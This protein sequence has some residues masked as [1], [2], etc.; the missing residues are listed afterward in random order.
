MNDFSVSELLET[1]NA[2]EKDA[3][4]LLGYMLFEFSRLDVNLGL[5]LVWVN[6]GENL[7]S[8]TRSV[9]GFTFKTRLDEL[10][11]RINAKLQR[12]SESYL[13]YEDWIPKSFRCWRAASALNVC[14]TN[15]QMSL[16]G[17][18]YA[19]PTGRFREAEFHWP[20]SGDEFEER[21]DSTRPIPAIRVVPGQ[22]QL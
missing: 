15:I 22:R 8:L 2:L 17:R 12:D 10:S 18:E 20:L 16:S 19:L 6:D 13:A 1:R 3:A 5:C 21:T 14:F 7:E 11:K 4:S 9:A